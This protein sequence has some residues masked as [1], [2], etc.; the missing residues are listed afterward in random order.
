[1]ANLCFEHE[2]SERPATY[3]LSSVKIFYRLIES[4][5]DHDSVFEACRGLRNLAASADASMSQY[6]IESGCVPKLLRLISITR[7]LKENDQKVLAMALG[8]LGNLTLV[9]DAHIQVWPF[10]GLVP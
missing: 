10:Y 1:M 8:V 2:K 5:A 9:S 3:F 6:L 4:G 7:T